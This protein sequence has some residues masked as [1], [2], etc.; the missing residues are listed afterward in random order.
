LREA[1]GPIRDLLNAA[2]HHAVLNWGVRVNLKK[3]REQPDQVK[4]FLKG[5]LLGLRY[6]R[7]NR[8]GAIEAMVNRLN[9]DRETADGV[10]QLSIK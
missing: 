8:D 9:L 2:D 7:Q 5:N 3:L 1:A 6:M 10:Y 4:R